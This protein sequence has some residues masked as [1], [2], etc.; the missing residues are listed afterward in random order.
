MGEWGCRL[1]KEK[2]SGTLS[3]TL[4]QIFGKETVGK[5]RKKIVQWGN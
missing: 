5:R 4:G 1:K 2:K 3:G